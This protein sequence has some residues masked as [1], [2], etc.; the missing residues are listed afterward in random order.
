MLSS[1]ADESSTGD[2]SFT[3]PHAI[4]GGVICNDVSL[5]QQPTCHSHKFAT[6]LSHMEPQRGQSTPKVYHM[7]KDIAQVVALARHARFS[8]GSWEYQFIPHFLGQHMPH[9]VI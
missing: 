4:G 6:G 3:V 8:Q 1:W 2:K 7:A 9:Q 5:R